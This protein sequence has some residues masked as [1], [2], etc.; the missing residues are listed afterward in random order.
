M[1]IR[2]NHDRHAGAPPADLDIDGH[3][4]A[5]LIP[6]F[7][8][9]HVPA[10]HPDGY[11]LAGHLHPALR[12]S[13]RYDSLRLPCFWL[14][15]RVAVLPAFGAFTGAFEVTPAASDRSFVVSGETVFALP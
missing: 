12:L 11:V 8:F 15:E 9:A 13:S 6:P 5:L 2:G 7:V 10:P 3:G 1:L 4:D 14:Q